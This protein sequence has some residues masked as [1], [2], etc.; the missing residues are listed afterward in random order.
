MTFPPLSVLSYLWRELRVTR[1]PPEARPA[2]SPQEL[3][4][5]PPLTLVAT[6]ILSFGGVK[7]LP[8][9]E[10]LGYFSEITT[11]PPFPH[12]LRSTSIS[13]V[14]S[15]YLRVS[16]LQVVFFLSLGRFEPRPLF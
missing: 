1:R 4:Y 10:K 8:D 13:H 15:D 2:P 12:T 11:I 16:Q 7:Q 6:P 9:P 14:N 5:F 3:S